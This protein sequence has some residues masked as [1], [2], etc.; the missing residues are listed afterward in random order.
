M[1]ELESDREPCSVFQQTARTNKYALFVSDLP[2]GVR[3]ARIGELKF[4]HV[5]LSDF[6][7]GRNSYNSEK[8]ARCLRGYDRRNERAKQLETNYLNSI[9]DGTYKIEA[10]QTISDIYFNLTALLSAAQFAVLQNEPDLL[11]VDLTRRSSTE[12]FILNH[13]LLNR[14]NQTCIRPA[15]LHYYQSF[16]RLG[17]LAATFVQQEYINPL[18]WWKSL[19]GIMEVVLYFLSALF[20]LTK[21]AS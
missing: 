9:K 12:Q 18:S 4:S 11:N 5:R 20:A 21:P 10:P 17:G 16:E 1:N 2:S 7:H 13:P 3:D 8:M 6:E 19:L 15:L 14:T